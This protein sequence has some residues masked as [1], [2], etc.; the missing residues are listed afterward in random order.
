M[1]KRIATKIV[2]ILM[3]V[4]LLYSIICLKKVSPVLFFLNEILIQI[5]NVFFREIYIRRKRKHSACQGTD[6]DHGRCSDS[7]IPGV[8]V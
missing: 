3:R 1:A 2:T 4:T 8:V 7:K 6:H 5:L